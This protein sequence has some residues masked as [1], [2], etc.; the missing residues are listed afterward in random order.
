MVCREDIDA[1]GIGILGNE[2]N[3]VETDY[4]KGPAGK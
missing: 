1:V 4:V 2:I 3:D